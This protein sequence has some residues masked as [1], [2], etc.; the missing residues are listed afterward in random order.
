[1]RH[2]G[3]RIVPRVLKRLCVPVTPGGKS[4]LKNPLTSSEVTD[5]DKADGADQAARARG[6]EV[7]RSRGRKSSVDEAMQRSHG[8]TGAVPDQGKMNVV[9]VEMND[10]ETG[11]ILKDKLHHVHMMRQGFATLLILPKRLLT[12]RYEVRPR[13][14][15]TAGEKGYFMPLIDEFFRKP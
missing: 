15:I 14:R 2:V 9:T 8:W 6:R 7:A 13:L 12:Y 5:L 10:V 3:V 4:V 1:M 11:Y